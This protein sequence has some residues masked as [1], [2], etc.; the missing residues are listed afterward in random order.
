[1]LFVFLWS[2]YIK[3]IELFNISL[4]YTFLAGFCFV[5]FASF[6]FLLFYGWGKSFTVLFTVC[7]TKKCLDIKKT[8]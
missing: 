5:L 6:V 2:S 3:E 4:F 7:K 1:M 8:D